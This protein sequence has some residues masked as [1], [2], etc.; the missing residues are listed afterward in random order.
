MKSEA[1]SA[2][3]LKAK[4]LYEAGRLHWNLGDFRSST[5][6]VE[7]AAELYLEVREFAEYF[8]CQSL[9]LRMHV[10]MCEPKA[11]AVVREQIETTLKKE[12]LGTP[13][14]VLTVYAFIAQNQGDLSKALDYLQKALATSLANGNKEDTCYAIYGLVVVY[15]ALNR[16]DDA[17]NEIYNL[18]VFFQVLDVPE[19]ELSTQIMNGYIF[20]NAKKYQEALSVFW[21]AMERL[22]TQKNMYSYLSILFAIGYTYRKMGDV[23]LARTYLILAKQIVDPSN[24]VLLSQKIDHELSK[25]ALKDVD[26]DL[27]FDKADHSVTEKKKGR[28]D[29]KNQFILMDLLK[30]FLKHPGEVFSK[31]ILAKTV[32]KQEYDPRYHDN[33]IYVTIK[34]LRQLIEPDYEKPKYIHRA[35]NGY[36]LNKGTRIS[37]Q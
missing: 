37:L 5:K 14:V 26:F 16:P 13:A 27:V 6:K 1:V 31:E 2:T 19:V 32:W 25:L 8:R 28:I 33:K 21:S 17:L 3:L 20:V 35:K 36:Y 23:N 29:F 24:F 30:L 15:S 11:A 18:K 34:R 4:S 10:E 7:S 9:I 12:K 22:K